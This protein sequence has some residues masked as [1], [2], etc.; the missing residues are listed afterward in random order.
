MFTSF[1]SLPVAFG[2]LEIKKTSVVLSAT[3]QIT[4]TTSL[5]KVDLSLRLTEI[6]ENF[7]VFVS[8][9]SDE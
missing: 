9:S 8:S 7:K 1:A 2:P 3:S 6:V 5:D 4:K